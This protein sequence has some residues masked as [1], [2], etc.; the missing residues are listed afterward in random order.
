MQCDAIWLLKSVV[1]DVK[2]I[3]IPT[4]GVRHWVLNAGV[5][6]TEWAAETIGIG[7]EKGGFRMQRKYNKV[8]VPVWEIAQS[9]GISNRQG[10]GPKQWELLIDRCI[11]RISDLASKWLLWKCYMA[12]KTIINCRKLKAAHDKF[13]EVGLHQREN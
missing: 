5:G 12:E 1:A 7:Q 8:T 2:T 4:Q 6:V 3:Q 10:A 13:V 9:M 11:T